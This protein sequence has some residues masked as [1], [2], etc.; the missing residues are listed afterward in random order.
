M[1]GDGGGWGSG[2]AC[3]DHPLPGVLGAVGADGCEPGPDGGVV[4]A[5]VVVGG[6]AGWAGAGDLAGV[7]STSTREASR[8]AGSTGS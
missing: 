4:G 2:L 5:A 1:A 7:G 8:S 6:V 3:P